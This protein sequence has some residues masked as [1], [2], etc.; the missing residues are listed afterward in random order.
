MK[1][2]YLFITTLLLS[3][4]AVQERALAD[5]AVCLYDS[6]DIEI[7]GNLTAVV[8][9]NRDLEITSEEGS[10]YAEF[11]VPINDYIE[12]GGLKGYTL[13]PGGRKIKIN[14]NDYVMLTGR[15]DREFG[16]KKAVLITLKSPAVG[17]ILH[18]EYRL[19]IK[20]LLYLPRIV[21]AN[22]YAVE[23]M[24]VR[25]KWTGK[26]NLNYDY[27][28][29][30][31]I[32][33]GRNALF[34]A[35]DLPE[36]HVEPSGCNNGL[37]LYLSA[38][39]FKFDGKKYDCNSWSDV[40]RFF[41]SISRQSTLSQTRTKQ[42]ASRL[43]A[44]Q[45]TLRDSLNVLF[46][47][48]ADSVSYVA[49][50]VGSGDFTPHECNQIIERRFGDCKDQS[51]LLSSLFRSAGIEAFPALISTYDYPNPGMLHPW[52]SFFD[53]T[54]VIVEAGDQ[55]Y[56]LD[57]SDPYSDIKH[58]PPRLRGKSFLTADGIS[59]LETVQPGP[60]PE[61]GFSSVF[62]V[63]ND[64]GG[65]RTDFTINYINDSALKYGKNFGELGNSQR[66]NAVRTI[67]SDAGWKVDLL[68]IERQRTDPDTFSIAG[69][70][71]SDFSAADSVS[72][73]PVGSP[74]I[75]YLIDNIFNN[76]RQTSYCLNKSLRLEELARL[77]D[78]EGRSGD[79]SEYRD[80]WVRE[81]LEFYDEMKYIGQDIIFRRVFDLDG[82]EISSED[83][84]AFRDFLLSRKNQR[85]VYF[86][87]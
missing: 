3:Q 27:S 12:F 40:G 84:N 11:A 32:A 65:I 72:G 31:K 52:P 5:G 74:L 35:D 7:K 49:L 9:V 66:D 45:T 48:V 54:M 28:G 78:M 85:Y 61:E 24:A 77:G 81:G 73:F 23:R 18:Y 42:L 87:D 26:I 62:M 10:A 47:F 46:D 71:R 14:K 6:T 79:L 2:I 22:S 37:Y 4:V 33:E 20:N 50:R 67:L 51:V 83:F 17:A 16:G 69:D 30:E 53:H 68:N 75:S 76:V 64:S 25:L 29:L 36:I 43:L 41:Q 60:S 82:R 56:I 38:D 59:G 70:F 58:I 13:L 39:R 19:D 80:Y 8:K 63:R 21:R 34:Y 86:H 1:A 15:M 57:P 44:G 55:K